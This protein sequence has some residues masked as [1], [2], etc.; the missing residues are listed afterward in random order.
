[1]AESGCRYH[2]SA[3]YPE[4]IE[5]GVRVGRLGRSSIRYEVGIFRAGEAEALAE[6]HFVHVMVGRVNMRPVEI[7]PGLRLYLQS[8]A[9]M[10][11]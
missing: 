10:V 4:R 2:A 8:L 7:P 6:A 5:A 3:A 9:M 11:D 1:M